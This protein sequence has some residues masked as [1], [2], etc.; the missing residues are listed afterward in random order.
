MMKVP[1]TPENLERCIC[2]GCPSFPGEGVFYCARGQSQ[3][4]VK[5]RGCTCGDCKN[6]QEYGLKDGYYCAAGVAGEGPQ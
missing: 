5:R 6:F 3:Q 1:A 2:A 4:A